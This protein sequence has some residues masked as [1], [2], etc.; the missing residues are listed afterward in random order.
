[1]LKRHNLSSLLFGV[2]LVIVLQKFSY[3]DTVFRFFLPAFMG[4]SLLL[5]IYN[6]YYLKKLQ[7]YNFWVWLRPIMLCLSILGVFA[8]VPNDFMRGLSLATGAVLLVF[9]ELALGKFSDNIN[10]NET[11]LISFGGIVAVSSLNFTFPK[12]SAIFVALVFLG[13]SLVSRSFLE[14]IPQSNK[15]KL[16]MALTLGFF[17]AQFFWALSFLPLHFSAL[18]LILF[19][20]F[21][22]LLIINYY[23]LFNILTAQKIKFH[24][25]LVAI[26]IAAVFLATPWAII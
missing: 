8:S 6:Y 19:G 4:F 1:M 14:F 20:L 21:Y 16:V 10:T 12:F 15:I 5:G 13:A 7:R 17:T 11:L 26:C 23:F 24:F 18:A 2:L 9:F 25:W 3:P 22:F